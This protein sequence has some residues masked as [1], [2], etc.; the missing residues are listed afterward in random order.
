MKMNS[1]TNEMNTACKDNSDVLTEILQGILTEDDLAYDI[2]S[3][4][5]SH[6]QSLELSKEDKCPFGNEDNLGIYENQSSITNKSSM[7]LQ[8]CSF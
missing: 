3:L 6:N 8:L 4:E 2:L 1:T 7:N 5:E